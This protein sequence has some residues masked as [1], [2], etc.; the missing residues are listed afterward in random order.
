M[1]IPP[2][3]LS[4]QA[5]RGIALEFVSREGTD[6][7]HKDWDMETKVEQ[8]LGQIAR[9]D[10]MILADPDTGSCNLV[11]RKD[12]EHVLRVQEELDRLEQ[13]DREGA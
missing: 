11:P 1:K 5:L 9:G 6:Y 4:E 12:G 10:V 3:M 13:V 7:G 8:V 2:S